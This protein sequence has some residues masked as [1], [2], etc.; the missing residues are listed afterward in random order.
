MRQAVII[1]SKEQ[2]R[3]S[4]NLHFLLNSISVQLN[5]GSQ[6]RPKPA[7]HFD[8]TCFL[9][10]TAIPIKT[11]LPCTSRFVLELWHWR[12][13]FL[14]Y[15][16]VQIPA[17]AFIFFAVCVFFCLVFFCSTKDASYLCFFLAF[18]SGN[19][20]KTSQNS[21]LCECYQPLYIPCNIIRIRWKQELFRLVKIL[22]YSKFSKWMIYRNTNKYII[23]SESVN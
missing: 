12:H 10:I 13:Q 19:V 15:P 11:V 23:G 9:E 1:T 22:D 21:Y 20:R 2:L 16:Q 14:R 18:W 8:E 17:A 5:C 6:W 4:I 3:K 7:L